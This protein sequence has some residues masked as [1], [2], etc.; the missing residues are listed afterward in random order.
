M[1]QLIQALLPSIITIA[2]IILTAVGTFLG[3]KLN[4]VL[5]TNLKKEIAEQ[6]V[7]YVE[8]VGKTLGS[9]E[10][11]NLAKNKIIDLALNAGITI[12]DAEIDV[13]IESVV[14]GFNQG[15]ITLGELEESL[16]E[17]KKEGE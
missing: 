2:V 3:K 7:K 13:L 15:Y 1:E 10:K 14:N 16:Q 5:N 11:F 17:T 6:T 8:Q 9:E 4:L 12:T